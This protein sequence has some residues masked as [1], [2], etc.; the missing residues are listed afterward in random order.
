MGIITPDSNYDARLGFNFK[1]QFIPNTQNYVITDPA[2]VFEAVSIKDNS[3]SRADCVEFTPIEQT[4]ADK[5]EGIYYAYA[6]VTKAADDIRIRPKCSLVPKVINSF[7]SF[8]NT[9]YP[10]DTSIKINFNKAVNLSDFTDE[11]GFLKNITITSGD[12]DLLD[13]TG[14]KLPY[15]KSPYLENE[16]QTLVIP[17]LK[18]NYLIKDNS[19][20]DISVS[21]KLE[22]L[23][24]GVEGEN[25][26]FIQKSYVFTFRI[27]SKKDTT[28][29]ILKTLRIARTEEDARNGTNLII[30]DEFTHYADNANYGGDSNVV[31]TNIQNH[32]V[33]KVWVYF[34]GE[35]ADSGVAGLEIR[36]QLIRTT[37]G[38]EI[39]G[40][41]YT[42]ESSE[43]KKQN[44]FEN[45]KEDNTYS[46]CVEYNF[47][48]DDDGVVKLDF[49]LHDRAGKNTDDSDNSS[50]R[51]DI[52][53]DTVC[54]L[55]MAIY[56]IVGYINNTQELYPFIITL[57]KK[58]TGATSYT[59]Y[60]YIKDING[61]EYE[62]IYPNGV[63]ETNTVEIIGLY[64]GYNENDLK[65][66][67]LEQTDYENL[68]NA[69]ARKCKRIVF[70]ADPYK[71]II[72]QGVIQ[73]TAGNIKKSSKVIPA[74]MD[75]S[76]ADLS[77]VMESN[78]IKLFINNFDQ[79]Q[80]Y[81]DRRYQAELGTEMPRGSYISPVSDDFYNGTVVTESIAQLFGNNAKNG[82]YSFSAYWLSEK[83]TSP[84]QFYSYRG[85]Y[86]TIKKEGDQYSLVNT[87][88]ETTPV[89][90]SDVPDINVQA[91]PP[92]ANSGI[93]RIHVTF[94]NFVPNPKLKY[95]IHYKAKAPGTSDGY[96]S[97]LDFSVPSEYCSYDFTAVVMNEIGKSYESEE[98]ETIDLSAD[99]ISPVTDRTPSAQEHPKYQ[100]L[101][102]YLSPTFGTL[103]IKIE[104]K[105][106]KN[107]TQTA[108]IKY[109]LSNTI[110]EKIDWSKDSRVK[111]TEIIKYN[112]T[113]TSAVWGFDV[114]SY[115]QEY[116]GY[117]YVLVQD[118]CGNYT[119]DQF[120]INGK[121]G[122]KITFNYTGSGFDL[123]N[124][125]NIFVNKTYI[126]TNNEWQQCADT[127]NNI[128]LSTEEKNSFI[129]LQCWMSYCSG[130][131]G[132]KESFNE[133]IYF[134]PQ[135][136]IL[137]ET[138]HP[139]ECDLKNIY[140]GMYGYDISADQPCFAHTM[141]CPHNLGDTEQAWLNSGYETGLVMKKK[142]FTYSYDNIKP[143]PAGYYYTTIVHFADGTTLMTPVKQK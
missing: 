114:V 93:R 70:D 82:Y 108:K 137:K 40:I 35:D 6:K 73:D 39:Q 34:E 68:D 64:Y 5:K 67:D 113:E 100:L 140:A 43:P 46:A 27:D 143:V 7:P 9:N 33:N 125:S 37:T 15:Y 32:H 101:F 41:I 61:K 81:L 60:I 83:P 116:P 56:D 12:V 130:G 62:D 129:K 76:F 95:F 57:T 136:Y 45:P 3:V 128:N 11:N 85:K 124:T 20:K 10:Q 16:N 1:L 53:K 84:Y 131:T 104:D 51:V 118:L 36:E 19:T 107:N 66:V 31:A 26:A 102:K 103:Q 88:N 110:D 119:E 63:E 121:K 42:R 109:V 111:E 98:A 79:K 65:Y 58:N 25:A 112:D 54:E 29:P 133:P 23:T 52:V 86:I 142:S 8:D 80:F 127:G 117:C 120:Y 132:Y 21:L 4:A 71:D 77:T 28:P 139:M 96:S 94:Q 59:R 75:V 18:G 22:S 38:E 69:S 97:V 115:T 138:E 122:N 78:S 90:Q 50:Y 123:S 48:S 74:A 24:D 72:V 87:S 55:E 135:Y 91:E 44:F 2:N 106:L 17:I 49:V 105:N 89:S 47:N 126:N 134:Y 30:M 14:G 141:Y 13:T 99:N 92:V